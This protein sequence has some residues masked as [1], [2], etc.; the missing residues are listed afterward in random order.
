MV[1]Q[2]VDPLPLLRRYGRPEE[3]CGLCQAIRRSYYVPTPPPPREVL[4]L[5]MLVPPVLA[6]LSV[7]LHIRLSDTNR[8][9]SVNHLPRVKQEFSK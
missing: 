3:G 8:A 5:L 9:E 7:V 1:T 6:I 4:V 2:R